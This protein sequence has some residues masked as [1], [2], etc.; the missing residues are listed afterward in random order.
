[1]LVE[2]WEVIF[3]KIEDLIV[4]SIVDFQ[5]VLLHQLSGCY[6]VFDYQLVLINEVIPNSKW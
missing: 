6:I 2:G 3:A 4:A 1:M 5:D